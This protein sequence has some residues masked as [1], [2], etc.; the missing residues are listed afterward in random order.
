MKLVLFDIDDT[1][2]FSNHVDDVCYIKACEDVLSISIADTNWNLYK[3]ATDVGIIEQL[4]TKHFK[5]EPPA[6]IINNI[7]DRYLKLLAHEMDKDPQ[8][9]REIPGAA[10]MVKL[11]IERKDTEVGIATGGFRETAIYKLNKLNFDIRDLPIASSNKL[12]TKK[13][14]ILDLINRAT[15]GNGVLDLRTLH[16]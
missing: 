1:L 15:S 9:F 8:A 7:R 4:Y 2:C 10:E 6:E 13:E 14:I 16:T 3:N 12:R 11:L 5:K